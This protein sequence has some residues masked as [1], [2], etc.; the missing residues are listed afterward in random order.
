MPRRATIA[1]IYVDD[2]VITDTDTNSV[3]QLKSHLEKVFGIKDLGR[4]H[5]FLGF[6]VNYTEDRIILSQHNFAK[7]LLQ[8]AALPKSKTVAGPLPLHFKVRADSEKFIS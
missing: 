4:L 8:E 7:E 1:A 5:Y 6:E 2:M 3:Q